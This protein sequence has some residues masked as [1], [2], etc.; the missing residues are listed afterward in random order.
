M[1]II[2]YKTVRMDQVLNL[3]EIKHSG[4][5]YTVTAKADRELRN[6]IHDLVCQ[7]GTK[8]AIYPT[9]ITT[10]DVVDNSYY[11]SIQS[12]VTMDD[13]FTDIKLN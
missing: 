12:I 3:C 8:Y 7:K 11:G 5:E 10:Y 13:L 6:K 9:L 1:L 2:E 4:S